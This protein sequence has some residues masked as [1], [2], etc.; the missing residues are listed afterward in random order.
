M[1][2]SKQT[3]TEALPLL[4]QRNSFVIRQGTALRLYLAVTSNKAM[5]M[6]TIRHVIL[7]QPY[8]LNKTRIAEM[9]RLKNLENLTIV[10]QWFRTDAVAANYKPYSPYFDWTRIG[11]DYGAEHRRLFEVDSMVDEDQSG[12]STGADHHLKTKAGTLSWVRRWINEGAGF[13]EVKDMIVARPRI[14]YEVV[15]HGLKITAS[16]QTD[17]SPWRIVVSVRFNVSWNAEE[18]R[19]TYW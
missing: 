5:K 1:L 11:L 18:Q 14:D 3:L 12:N 7:S 2:V 8:L 19:Y 4:Y 9:K 16:E 10:S 17:G 15:V 13:I 6:Y